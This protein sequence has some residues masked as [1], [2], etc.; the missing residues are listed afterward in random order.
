MV[1]KNK[2][3][4]EED[5]Y[6]GGKYSKTG[7]FFIGLGIFVGLGAVFGFLSQLVVFLISGFGGSSLTYSYPLELFITL[8][9]AAC[10]ILQFV[11]PFIL[12]NKYFS[13]RRFVRMG[14]ITCIVIIGLIPFLLFGWCILALAS[15]G[16]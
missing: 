16:F 10:I 15:G 4:F 11:L 12:A 8:L 6:E 14:I 13:E 3:L 5:V 9:F 7:D 2:K 1:E